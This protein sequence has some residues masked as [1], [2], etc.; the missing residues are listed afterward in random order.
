MDVNDASIEAPFDPN[1]VSTTTDTP[2]TPGHALNTVTPAT[3][4][5]VVTQDIFSPLAETVTTP[6]SVQPFTSPVIASPIKLTLAAVK[7]R[8]DSTAQH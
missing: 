8:L 2:G 5:P 7:R 4:V 3:G 6:P 1:I